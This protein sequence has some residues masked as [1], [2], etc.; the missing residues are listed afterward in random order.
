MAESARNWNPW[1]MRI[2]T[3]APLPQ[4]LPAAMPTAFAARRTSWMAASCS[5]PGPVS[6][7]S[8]ESA[9]SAG[10]MKQPEMPSTERIASACSTALTVSIITMI[11][12]FSSVHVR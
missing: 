9:R 1:A 8:N 11:A 7:V 5:V 4:C 12:K 3:S 6:V 10:P 2:E